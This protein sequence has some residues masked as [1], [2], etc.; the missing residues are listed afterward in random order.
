MLCDAAAVRI[1]NVSNAVPRERLLAAA[2]GAMAALRNLA[3][4]ADA[5]LVV[6]QALA[7][8]VA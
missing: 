7:A 1:P 6:E 2:D 5:R 8:L 4:N 3:V